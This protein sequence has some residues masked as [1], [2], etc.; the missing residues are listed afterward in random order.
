MLFAIL[1]TVFKTYIA[2]S[3][4]NYHTLHSGIC[5]FEYPAWLIT[6]TYILMNVGMVVILTYIPE[7]SFDILQSKEGWSDCSINHSLG[8]AI[9]LHVLIFFCS[10]Q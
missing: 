5:V 8:C 9:D 4:H 2:W 3:I 1:S 7:F 6:T 10:C